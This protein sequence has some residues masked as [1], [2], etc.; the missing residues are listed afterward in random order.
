MQRGIEAVRD[1]GTELDIWQVCTTEVARHGAIP[2]HWETSAGTRSAACFPPSDYQLA[3]GDLIR[4][5]GGC[6]YNWNFAD[7][8]RTAVV[9]KPTAEQQ[10]NYD[11]IMAGQQAALEL[12]RPGTLPSE[13]FEADVTAVRK[14]GLE[15]YQRHHVGHGIGLEMYEAPLLAPSAKSDIHKLGRGEMALEPQMVINVETPYYHLG[16][17]GFQIEDTVVVTEDGYEYLT[18][19]PRNLQII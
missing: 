9:G 3:Q 15:D 2:T 7:T 16:V 1:G 10:R 6:R 13:I 8:G 11:A 17:G 19:A 4:I 5:E 18:H 12:V 14:A